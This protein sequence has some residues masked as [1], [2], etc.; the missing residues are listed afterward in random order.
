MQCPDVSC[1]A[2]SKW[3]QA[4]VVM[5]G[6]GDRFVSMHLPSTNTLVRIASFQIASSNCSRLHE[7]KCLWKGEAMD[8][9]QQLVSLVKASL[10]SLCVDVRMSRTFLDS[11]DSESEGNFH[12]GGLHFHEQRTRL[13]NLLE[14]V[15]KFLEIVTLN[16][17]SPRLL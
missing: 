5:T 4:A 6:L 7:I 2:A 3:D 16:H 11:D 1:T 14:P 8:S 15:C 9:L 12:E 13:L 10:V 17:P